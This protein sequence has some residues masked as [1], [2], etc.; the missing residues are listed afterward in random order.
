MLVCAIFCYVSFFSVPFFARFYFFSLSLCTPQLLPFTPTF[1]AVG[2]PWYFPFDS[3]QSKTWKMLT[4][5]IAL[6]KHTKHRS[7]FC[8]SHLFIVF[9]SYNIPI[10]SPLHYIL[11]PIFFFR[12]KCVFFCCLQWT[13]V[14][15]K[16]LFSTSPLPLLI[17]LFFSYLISSIIFIAAWLLVASRQFLLLLLAV[18]VHL[19]CRCQRWTF[20]KWTIKILFILCLADGY[21]CCVFFFVFVFVYILRC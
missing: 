11:S 15:S 3:F 20:A 6:C 19:S 21:V 4:I 10:D 1:R 12:R 18:F 16:V 8:L 2:C 9:I 5:E 17:I 7:Q 13:T 14:C